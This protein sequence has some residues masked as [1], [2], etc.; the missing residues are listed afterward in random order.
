MAA[1]WWKEEGESLPL[2]LCLKQL[3]SREN[4]GM[5]RELRDQTQMEASMFAKFIN[6]EFEKLNEVKTGADLHRLFFRMVQFFSL[7]GLVYF[8]VSM[9]PF[10]FQLD[11]SAYVYGFAPSP[12][13]FTMPLLLALV[14]IGVAEFGLRLM[15]AG[16][17]GGVALGIGLSFW[18]TFS[19][20]F[21]FGFFGLFCFLNSSFQEKYAPIFPAYFSN[22][23]TA[24][25]L[26]RSPVKN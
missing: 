12:L 18:F 11:Q 25:N 24:M 5:G 17:F 2:F 4:F 22:L 19:W 26:S 16:K 3:R 6:T 15:A 20:L 1:A 14:Q 9:M 8:L 21:L 23:L 7:L 13:Y 10:L